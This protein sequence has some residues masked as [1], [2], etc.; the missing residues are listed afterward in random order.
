LQHKKITLII[1]TVLLTVAMFFCGCSST[2]KQVGPKLT[3][4]WAYAPNSIH[5]HPLSRIR[6]TESEDATIIVHI[7]LLD[8]D[9]FA[10][11]GIGILTVKATT[12]SGDFLSEKIVDLQEAA[13]NREHFDQV[14]RTYRV[15]FESISSDIKRTQ[16]RASF[17]V[18]GDEVLKSNTATLINHNKD[19]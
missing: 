18:A 1:A 4:Q 5:I 15:Q 10:C 12:P 19:N 17:T 7:S 14:T 8:G 2:P 9:G 6:I 16:L 11:R 3:E 13:T